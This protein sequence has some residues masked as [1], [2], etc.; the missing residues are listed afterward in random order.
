MNTRNAVASALFLAFAC[1]LPATALADA[2]AE[3][4]SAWEKAMAKGSYRMHIHSEVRGRPYTTQ[5]DIEFPSSFHMR[6]PDTE[7]VMLPEGTW[8]QA[9]GQ[10]MRSP[11]NMS[12]QVEGYTAE[13]L[14]EGKR[15]L[16]SVERIG[17]ETVE[18]CL[19]TRYR[20]SQSGRFMGIKN[21]ADV[22]IAVCKDSGLPREVRSVSGSKRRPE[23][24][25]IVYD[26]G[27]DIRI[28]APR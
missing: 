4:I 12:R 16:G 1:C 5:M 14:E 18:G 27:A 22:E 21:D 6:T 10:W 17:E 13:A 23:T 3:V 20:Y 2:R 19:A 25:R 24:T 28:R 7:M 8:I 9:G 15:S 11:V 26:F